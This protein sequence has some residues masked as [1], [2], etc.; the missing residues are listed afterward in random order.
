[1]HK[2]QLASLS[3]AKI[4]E[5]PM[6]LCDD[7]YSLLSEKNL[8]HVEFLSVQNCYKHWKKAD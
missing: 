2:Q 8:S 6:V 7:D 3:D 5:T 1:M 4:L